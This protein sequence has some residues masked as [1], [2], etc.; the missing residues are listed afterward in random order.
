MIKVIARFLSAVLVFIVGFCM[1]CSWIF[2]RNY[3]FTKDQCRRE[4]KFIRMFGVLNYW[5]EIKREH[6]EIETY[7]RNND[8]HTIAVYGIGYLGK[9][10]VEELAQS[11]I[12]VKYIVDKKAEQSPDNIVIY[13]PDDLFPEAD[14]IV[15]TAI[16]DFDEISDLLESKVEC[17]IVSLE[18][19]I[20]EL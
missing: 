17:P 11:D 5:F 9:H 7:F 6:K 13:R 8:F 10:F 19:I 15:V 1:G 18:D 12:T 2:K 16:V 4:N 3:E 20:Y 14:V